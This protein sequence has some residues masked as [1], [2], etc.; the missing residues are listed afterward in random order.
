MIPF[1]APLLAGRGLK[2]LLIG[3]AVAAV[4]FAGFLAYR[5]VDGLTEKV[6]ILSANNAKLELAFQEAQARGDALRDHIQ[7]VAIEVEE[8]NKRLSDL[9]V[10]AATAR[11]EAK[12][13]A[14]LFAKHDFKGLVNAKPELLEKRINAGTARVQR[15][16]EQASTVGGEA[17]SGAAAGQ[18]ATGAASGSGP[19]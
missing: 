11:A 5:Y 4:G 10:E 15:L 19:R 13:T 12:A 2:L 18:G 14:N 17:G 1:I 9:A 7:R 3:G 8:N 16:L 6:A